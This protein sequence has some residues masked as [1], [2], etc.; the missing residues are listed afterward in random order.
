MV[1]GA[2]RDALSAELRAAH[3]D[4]ATEQPHEEYHY[5]PTQWYEPY[6]ARRRKLGWDLYGLLGI[7]KGDSAA[8]SR[9]HALNYCFF[10]AP[11]GLFFTLD[12]RLEI[13]SWLDLGM[14][15][16]NVMVVA[17]SIGLDTCPRAAFT[18]YHRIIRRHLDIPDG[19][20]LVSGMALGNADLQAPENRLKTERA[21][22]REFTRF[23]GF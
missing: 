1:G 17:R 18:K 15:M 4:P 23:C 8:M 12:H 14:F 5:Y 3:H 6:L 19:E 20:I 9:Q 16:E 22:I 21:P 10:G 2:A 13:G 7:A 11:V